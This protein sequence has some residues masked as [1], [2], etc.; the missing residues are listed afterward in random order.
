MVLVCVILPFRARHTLWCTTR[1]CA[2][3]MF[4]FARRA[5]LT[6]ELT[7]TMLAFRALR[8]PFSNI[9]FHHLRIG[10][11]HLGIITFRQWSSDTGKYQ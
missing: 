10:V 11:S 4:P 3:S 2:V 5:W 1:A 6:A 7:L 8:L 9:Q